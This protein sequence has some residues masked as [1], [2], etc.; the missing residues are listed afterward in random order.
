MKRTWLSFGL[1]AALIFIGLPSWQA[2]EKADFAYDDFSK[3][4]QCGACHKEIYQEWQQSLMSQ[5]FTHPWDDAEYFKLALPHAFKLEKVAGVKSDCIACHGPLAFLTGDIPPKPPAA[6]TR[7]N[8]GVSCDVCHS[9]TGSSGKEPFN[10]SYTVNPGKT[11]YGVRK[12]AESRFHETEYSAFT[13]SPELCATC[14]DEKSPYGAWVK[15][16][17]REW[18]ASPYAGQGIRCQDCHMHHAPG[19]SSVGG[20][21]RD[22]IAH[23]VFHG[24]HFSQKLKGS[25]DLALY[26][27]KSEVKAGS[28]VVI[29]AVL[30]NGKAGHFIPSGSSEERMLWL[31]VQGKDHEGRVYRIPVDKKGFPGEEFTIADSNALAYQAMGEIMDAPGYKGVLRDGDVP[32]GSRIFRRP[33]FDPQGRMTICQWFTAK[34]NEIDYRIGPMETKVETYT[35][36]VPKELSAQQVNIS[37]TLYYSLVPSSVAKLMELPSYSCEPRPVNSASLVLSVK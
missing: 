31:E 1:A 34:N 20:K 36:N 4:M 32:D 27:D 13:A 37:A 3:P 10:F 24:P 30:Y 8:E 15:E 11:K 16:T 22:D 14:H 23:H 35:W 6:G 2:A 5:S 17:Y 19:K 28:K 9:M 26:A 25:V 29:R 7:V 12:D 33:Y 18:K 21:Q